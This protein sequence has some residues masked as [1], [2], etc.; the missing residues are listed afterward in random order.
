MERGGLLRDLDWVPPWLSLLF[1]SP[2]QI[3]FAHL[4]DSWLPMFEK[5]V[6]ILQNASTYII[7]PILMRIL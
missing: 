4:V 5:H 7:H 1:F 3:T 6:F 2:D